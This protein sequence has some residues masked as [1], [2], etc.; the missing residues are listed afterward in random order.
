MADKSKLTTLET[1]LTTPIHPL[2]IY[3]CLS[4]KPSLIFGTIA[5]PE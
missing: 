4:E 5:R 1:G 2:P 3:H